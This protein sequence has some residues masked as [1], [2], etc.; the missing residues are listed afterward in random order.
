MQTEEAPTAGG[1][2]VSQPVSYGLGS[3]QSQAVSP[4]KVSVN[5]FSTPLPVK[6]KNFSGFLRDH[7][8]NAVRERRFKSLFKIFSGEEQ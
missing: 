8:L 2:A 6:N 4:K 5:A 3:D 1:S 7:R